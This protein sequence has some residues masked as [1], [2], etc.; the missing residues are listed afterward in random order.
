MIVVRQPDY[1]IFA[2]SESTSNPR[3]KSGCVCRRQCLEFEE[4]CEVEEESLPALVEITV[5]VR[6]GF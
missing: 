2:A 5:S 1:I 3:S 4:V 6:A